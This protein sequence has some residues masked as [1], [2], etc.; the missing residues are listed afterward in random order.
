[1]FGMCDTSRRPSLG[2]MQVVQSRDA[3]TLLPIIQAHIHPGTVI[4]SD[5]WRA[6]SN[7]Q[8]LAGVV[9]HHTVNHSLHFVDPATGVHTQNT[10]SYW[11]RVKTKLKRMRGC[12]KNQFS[13]Y[14]DEFMWRERYGQTIDDVINNIFRD[15]SIWYPV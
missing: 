4:Y 6:Y 11:Q 1:M 8:S 10:E 14:L 5:S 7:V 12:H 15:M 9:Q 2:F 3:N 13:S